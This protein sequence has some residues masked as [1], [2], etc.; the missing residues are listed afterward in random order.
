MEKKIDTRLVWIAAKVAAKWQEYR[1]DFARFATPY[2]REWGGE[3]LVNYM[4]NKYVNNNELSVVE[5]L[6]NLDH[7]NKELVVKYLLSKV[8]RHP[9]NVWTV[10]LSN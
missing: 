1:E 10:W 5:Y 6:H 4:M 7:Y 9:E 3:E 2:W 8:D